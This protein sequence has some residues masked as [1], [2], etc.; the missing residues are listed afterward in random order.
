MLDRGFIRWACVV[1]ALLLSLIWL[2]SGCGVI[3][4]IPGWIP[5]SSVFALAL[6]VALSWLAPGPP[7]P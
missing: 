4:H 3:G 1:A 6:G 7:V 2:L 5:P